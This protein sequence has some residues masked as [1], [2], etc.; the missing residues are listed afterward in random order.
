LIFEFVDLHGE[1]VLRNALRKVYTSFESL[2]K[3]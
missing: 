1:T 2:T 3:R